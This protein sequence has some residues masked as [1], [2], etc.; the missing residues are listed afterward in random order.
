[1]LSYGG[2]AR[3][4]ATM[5]YKLQN[6]TDLGSDSY[7]ANMTGT[8]SAGKTSGADASATSFLTSYK[9]QS[10][11]LEDSAKSLLA[12]NA[13]G[14][15]RQYTLGSE[16]ESV[17]TASLKNLTEGREFEVN[18][19]NL[20]SDTEDARFEITEN[21]KTTA[22]TSKSNTATLEDGNL[23]INLN[24]AGSTKVYTGVDED[25]IVSAMKNLVTDFNRVYGTLSRNAG[26]GS[27]MANQYQN[28]STVLTDKS[29]SKLGLSYN[30][31]G[32][33]LDEEAFKKQLETDYEGT[34]NLVG[35]QNGLATQIASKA[36]SALSDSVSDIMSNAVNQNNASGSLNSANISENLT[37]AYG[38]SVYQY[39]FGLSKLS[40]VNSYY[41]IGSLLNT[42]A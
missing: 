17:A 1:M 13:E 3:S 25:K 27:S 14:V 19:L 21:G 31:G 2:T 10:L 37:T 16:D 18:V 28:F 6:L 24:K 29:L 33:R 23:T 39:M 41:T 34:M 36:S 42:L 30:S 11:L 8:G 38:Q 32:L 35:G 9:Y 20:A 26:M 5:M 15:F 12:D 4:A 40:S 22:Y 7:A